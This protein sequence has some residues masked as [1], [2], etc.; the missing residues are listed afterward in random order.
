MAIPTGHAALCHHFA[1][2]VDAP[3]PFDVEIVLDDQAGFTDAVVTCR[4]CGQHV[5]LELLEGGGARFEARVYRASLVP[6]QAVALYLKDRARGSCDVKRAGAEAHAFTS[7]AE[8]TPHLVALDLGAREVSGVV[9]LPD[10]VDVPMTSWR[11]RS[12]AA[13]ANMWRGYFT[14]SSTRI[15]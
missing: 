14:R 9:R 7:L 8:L 4:Y 2:A 6:T 3:F 11:E 10:G 12:A 5:L 1:D 13:T 15:E